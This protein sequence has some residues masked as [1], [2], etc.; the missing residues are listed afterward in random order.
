MYKAGANEVTSSRDKRPDQP[1]Y[2]ESELTELSQKRNNRKQ[3]SSVKDKA[4]D[5]FTVTSYAQ[6]SDST[7]TEKVG[8]Y[9]R[10]YILNKYGDST[11]RRELADSSKQSDWIVEKR[12]G[13]TYF[14]RKQKNSEIESQV[15]LAFT[16]I[17][18][19]GDVEQRRKKYS[20]RRAMND[21]ERWSV[22]RYD[23]R[24][25]SL[26]RKSGSVGSY[27]S[28]D[29]DEYEYDSWKRKRSRSRSMDKFIQQQVYDSRTRRKNRGSSDSRDQSKKH[30]EY[31]DHKKPV[32]KLGKLYSDLH[33]G[34]RDTYKY[35]AKAQV[36]DYGEFD[37]RKY[38]VSNNT[39][40]SEPKRPKLS[41]TVSVAQTVKKPTLS[42]A[43]KITKTFNLS[44]ESKSEKKYCEKE[45]KTSSSLRNETQKHLK[46]KIIEQSKPDGA[47]NHSRKSKPHKSKHKT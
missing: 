42:S 41:S 10:T 19:V 7:G 23:D 35:S 37:A 26:R 2:S 8:G 40:P 44:S 4:N 13:R 9:S 6:K 34:K 17:S 31:D 32:P 46:A 45:G 21:D 24:G 30:K 27:D 12:D 3:D 22:E 36:T 20:S 14:S 5:G 1:I 11:E 38:A 15:K 18:F 29:R 43:V 33:D 47:G 25:Y 39:A 16:G 28:R